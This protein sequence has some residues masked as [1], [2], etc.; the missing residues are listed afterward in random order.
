MEIEGIVRLDDVVEVIQK[1]GFLEGF[2]KN[3]IDTLRK[4]VPNIRPEDLVEIVKNFPYSDLNLIT[5]PAKDDKGNDYY[6]YEKS[7]VLSCVF[8]ILEDLFKTRELDMSRD[9]KNKIIRIVEAHL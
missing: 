1:Q 8:E 9:D 6:Y 3:L 2:E 7:E 5:F 4:D